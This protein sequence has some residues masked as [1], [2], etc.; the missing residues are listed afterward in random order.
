[1]ASFKKVLTGLREAERD[2]FYQ[3]V[4]D[5]MTADVRHRTIEIAEAFDRLDG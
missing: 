1:M 3:R 5:E 2:A 4:A